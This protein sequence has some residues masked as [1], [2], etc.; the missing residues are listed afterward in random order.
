[1]SYKLFTFIVYFTFFTYHNNIQTQNISFDAI[2]KPLLYGVV[3]LGICALAAKGLMIY[4][5]KRQ[6]I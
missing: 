1:M 4:C 2:K 3:S 6:E 5:K